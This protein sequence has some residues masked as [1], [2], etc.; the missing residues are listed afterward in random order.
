MEAA[1]RSTWRAR[2]E[3]PP[4]STEPRPGDSVDI[5]SRDGSVDRRTVHP[6]RDATASER[7][8]WRLIGD[9]LGVHWPMLDEDISVKGLLGSASA[10]RP[11]GPIRRRRWVEPVDAEPGR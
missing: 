2:G 4:A 7:A 1:T 3:R 8:A 11:G 6:T 10:S 9:G 5:V